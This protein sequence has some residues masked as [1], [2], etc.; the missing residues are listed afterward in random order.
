L[1][2]RRVTTAYNKI[3]D[4]LAAQ[5][6]S[7]ESIEHYQKALEIVTALAARYPQA[8]EWRA[9]AES[10]SAKIRMLLSKS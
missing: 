7:R 1:W 10:L 5:E 6:R 2:Q 3:G 8:A 4:L 9:L